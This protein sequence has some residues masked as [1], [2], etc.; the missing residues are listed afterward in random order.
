[1]KQVRCPHCSKLLYK[2]KGEAEIEIRC[3]RCRAMVKS[4]IEK[5]E[6]Q[7]ECQT[8]GSSAE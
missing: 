3:P 5:A 4:N 6:H 8:A 7:L 1:M 2:I